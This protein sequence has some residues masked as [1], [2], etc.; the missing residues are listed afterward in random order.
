VRAADQAVTCAAKAA[1]CALLRVRTWARASKLIASLGRGAESLA[2]N[3][4]IPARD[5]LVHD[6]YQMRFNSLR[7][8]ARNR[9][10]S[11][12]LLLELN[13]LAVASLQVFGTFMVVIKF[14]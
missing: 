11:R 12:W 3:T 1:E 7:S 13:T 9:T 14:E 2:H 8:D 10:P 4:V 5:Y 6:W